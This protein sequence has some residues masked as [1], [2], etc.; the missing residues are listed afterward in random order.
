MVL[1]S[2]LKNARVTKGSF[3]KILHKTTTEL[4]LK[5]VLKMADGELIDLF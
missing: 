5:V 2:F 4:L 3:V 1:L